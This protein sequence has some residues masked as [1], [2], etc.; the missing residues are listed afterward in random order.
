ML[1]CLIFISCSTTR[2]L[3]EG[4]KLYTGIDHIDILDE[5]KTVAG[6]TALE[7]VEA[8]LAHPPNNSIFGSSSMRWPLPIGLW[9]YN[10]FEKYQDKKGVTPANGVSHLGKTSEI[11]THARTF[12]RLGQ[13]VVQCSADYAARI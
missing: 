3:P 1:A 2:N 7:E 5:D 4:E 11:G 9:I 13:D 8:A 12:L 10:G 6:I